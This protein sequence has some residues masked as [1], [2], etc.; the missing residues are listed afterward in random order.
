MITLIIYG[1]RKN[2]SFLLMGASALMQHSSMSQGF[3]GIGTTSPNTHLHV[4]GKG[5][6]TNGLNVDNGGIY[7]AYAN[8]NAIEGYGSI[9]QGIGVY[10]YGY[11]GLY[12]SGSTFGV[13]AAGNTGV[14]GAGATYGVHGYSNAGWA[15]WGQSNSNLGVYGQS[16]SNYA[17]YAG[18]T[19]YP[20][21]YGSSN[22][23][24]VEAHS[25]T[26]WG[27][28]AY[29][30]S[31]C[32]A[33][34]TT[35]YGIYGTSTDGYGGYFY[36]ANSY[37]LRAATGRADKSW[38]GVFDGNV[39][40]YG[41]Y[42]PSDKK[43]K[44]NIESFSG[45]LDIINSLNPKS[46]EFA[47]ERQMAPHNLPPGKHYG[48]IAQDME[49]VLPGLVK[50]VDLT[51][52]D[53]KSQRAKPTAGLVGEISEPASAAANVAKEESLALQTATPT[54]RLIVKSVNYT[55]LIP[56][57]VRAMQEQDLRIRQQDAENKMLRQELS[58][59]RQLVSDLK[60][61]R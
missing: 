12:G 17:V 50:E 18:S 9:N 27:A 10:G 25:G 14:Y 5:R 33:Q 52:V 23:Y 41:A 3:V 40:V 57:M 28:A 6:F 38:A 60:G 61:K 1:M 31:G 19:S 53:D 2:L 26:T 39:Y 55:E 4:V 16:G 46:Y 34:A 21:V 8:G 48:F 13:Y 32:Y 15:V 36:S 42:Q 37:A 47:N 11:Y 24:G 7:S 56:L 51:I 43:L 59:L 22:H 44:K 29:G 30:V 54:E 35:G 49:Q 58:E 20:A 45:A